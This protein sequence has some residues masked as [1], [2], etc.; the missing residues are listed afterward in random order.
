MA[1]VLGS[2]YDI[3]V[4]SAKAI[5]IGAIK[6]WSAV[7]GSAGPIEIDALDEQ[8]TTW[9]T[10]RHVVLESGQLPSGARRFDDS[11]QLSDRVAAEKGAIGFVGLAYVRSA[12]AVAI[13]ERGLGATL[14]SPFTVAT[15]TYPLSRRLYLYTLP[16][17]RTTVASD[18]VN[19]ALGPEGQQIVRQNGF[20]DLTIAVLGPGDCDSRCPADYA[21]A[22]RGSRRLTL[23]FRFRESG[24]LDSRAFRDLDR[25]VAFLRG[26]PPSRLLLLGFG[27]DRKESVDGAKLVAD[28]LERRGVK[29]AAVMGFGPAMP[30]SSRNDASGRQRNHRV[31][32]WIANSSR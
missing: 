11:A 21:A 19:F 32:V 20:V 16:R 2:T 4:T 15:E 17:S 10:F 28:E 3:F 1:L 23:D 14:P 13:S 8:S 26:S 29:G 22:T 12:S 18:F 30:I 27:R 5:F 6:D 7:G 24:M 31:E 9:D 25:L